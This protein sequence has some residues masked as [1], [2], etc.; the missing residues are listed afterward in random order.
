MLTILVNVLLAGR[1]RLSTH[2]RKHAANRLNA[3]NRSSAWLWSS[4]MPLTL[5][6]YD[7]QLM[8]IEIALSTQ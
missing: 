8:A 3:S 7:Q 2:Q 6:L 4:V 1:Q 5:L